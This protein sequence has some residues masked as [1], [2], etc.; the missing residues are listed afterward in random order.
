MARNL[1]NLFHLLEDSVKILLKLLQFFVPFESILPQ[2]GSRAGNSVQFPQSA[3]SPICAGLHKCT[4][5]KIQ[6][7]TNTNT[8]TNAIQNTIRNVV[9]KKTGLCGKNS[10]TGGRGL[11]QTH[12]IFFSV[13]SNSG[14]YK[15]AKKIFKKTIK[16]CEH[17]QTGNFSHIIPFFF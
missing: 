15:M 6:K 9:R 10:Q 14:A 3:A 8:N 13:F 4:T 16:K 2:P 1:D 7:N 12:S 17:S 5:L 11:T